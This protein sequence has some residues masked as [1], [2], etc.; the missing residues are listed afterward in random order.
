MRKAL[1]EEILLLWLKVASTITVL[2]GIMAALASHP[3][4]DQL[5][6]LLFDILSWPLDGVP[7]AFDKVSRP[8]NAVLGGVMIGWGVL[9]YGLL[10]KRVFSE[11]I[12]TLLLRSILL[13][14][15]TD[16]IGS[17]F[18]EIPGNVLLNI[19][20]LVMFLP[21]LLLLKQKLNQI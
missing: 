17:F 3:A 1:T 18:A 20:F 16:S 2:T 6:L 8:L 9:M 11:A 15:V 12:R 19:S 10:Q 14:F 13:W 4:G 7:N 5:W 21:P